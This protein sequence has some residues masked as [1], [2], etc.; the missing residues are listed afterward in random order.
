MLRDF[1]IDYKDG[2]FASIQ[3]FL[4]LHKL[5]R[6][7]NAGGTAQAPTP[8]SK[9]N[10]ARQ[11][12]LEKRRMAKNDKKQFEVTEKTIRR[13]IPAVKRVFQCVAV[14]VA[15]ILLLQ[16]LVMLTEWLVPHKYSL[17]HSLFSYFRFLI[18]MPIFIIIR[19]LS[20]LWFADV[21]NAALA[22]RGT[23]A[24]N[25][26]GVGSGAIPDFSRAAADFVHAII[27]ELLFLAQAMAIIALE[28]PVLSTVG[29]FVYMSLLHSLYSFEYMWMSRGVPMSARLALVERRW[30][31]H[32]GFGTL[33]TLSTMYSDSFII[34]GCIFGA[35]FPLFIV[36]SYLASGFERPPSD[37]PQIHFFYI[38]QN[39]TNKL[40]V[41]LFGHIQQR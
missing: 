34:N 18:I 17:L 32:L 19:A 8:S 29:G 30:P 23:V 22:Y 15:S 41:A 31:F 20:T 28:V 39:L 27:V 7:A 6:P 16:L 24:S 35:L 4:V 25:S 33:L 3:G 9:E 26:G 2:L 1:L 37:V 40:S 12:V 38:A 36:S 5:D 13:K 11:T 14:N 21:A 10:N